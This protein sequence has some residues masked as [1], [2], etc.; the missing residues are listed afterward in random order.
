VNYP[1]NVIILMFMQTKI[2]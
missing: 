2:T 1:F